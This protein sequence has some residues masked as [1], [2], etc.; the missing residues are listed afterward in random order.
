MAEQIYGRNS[1]RITGQSR[2]LVVDDELHNCRLLEKALSRKNFLVTTSSG[3]TQALDYIKSQY[4]DLVILDIIMPDMNGLSVLS[5]IRKIYSQVRLPVIMTTAIDSS[6]DI[7]KALHLGAN[8]YIT[9]PFDLQVLIA[10]IETHLELKL[11]NETLD[12]NYRQL[13][14]DLTDAAK[15]QL[16]LFPSPNFHVP[17]IKFA[18]EYR[19]CIELGGDTLNIL[20]LDNDHIGMYLLD[21]SG[22]GVKAALLSTA[23][24]HILSAMPSKGGLVIDSSK[25]KSS[26]R[27]IPPVEVVKRLNRRF[28]MNFSTFQFFTILYGIV[29]LNTLKFHY[30]TAGHPA[31]ILLSSNGTISQEKS[32]SMAIGLVKNPSYEEKCI[33]LQPGD[34]I[35]LYSD[36]AVEAS[37]D[38]NEQFSTEQFIQSILND[39]NHSISKSSSN[40]LQRIRD[41]ISGPPQDDISVLAFEISKK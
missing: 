7:I 3:A 37:N 11:V 5:E 12:Y 33:S 1:L 14:N 38:D 32:R 24:S 20:K 39:R 8:D 16:S 13:K 35:Y 6:E 29:N 4:F 22:H 10:R 27:I 15:V 28:P 25:R 31:P 26:Q 9:K 19:P 17:S 2:I 36:G 34:R 41:W 18:W 40:L 30:V 23:L 21:V